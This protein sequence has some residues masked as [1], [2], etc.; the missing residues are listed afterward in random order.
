MVRLHPKPE[1]LN[2]HG[3]LEDATWTF[4]YTALPP[5]TV[6]LDLISVDDL[7][8]IVEALRRQNN[9]AVNGYHYLLQSN[10]IP[11]DALLG[12]IKKNLDEKGNETLQKILSD[13]VYLKT[14]RDMVLE[15]LRIK[16]KFI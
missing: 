11:L 4:E 6:A 15:A 9:D 12:Q 14:M 13:F 7:S 2:G 3:S 10:N 1:I 16:S 8:D 5:E